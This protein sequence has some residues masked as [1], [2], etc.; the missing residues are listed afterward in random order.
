MSNWLWNKDGIWLFFGIFCWG[1]GIGV[2]WA[3]WG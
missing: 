3:F 1:L 2:G